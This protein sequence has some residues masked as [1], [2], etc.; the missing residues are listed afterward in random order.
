MHLFVNDSYFQI[1]YSSL[2][3]LNQ[4]YSAKIIAYVL[5]VNHIHLILY[6]ESKNHL[7]DYMRDFKK[8]TAVKL[9][10]LIEHEGRRELLEKLRFDSRKQKFKIW[11]GPFDDV[12]IRSKRVLLIK[13]NY[14]HL[15]PVKKNLVSEAE[16]YKHSSAGF[17]LKEKQPLIPI[18][19]YTEIFS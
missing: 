6:F 8:F 10:Q 17:Y 9:R 19:H 14:I 4:K 15:N 2:L 1:L 3:F 12:V 5:M 18:L 11:M 13:M 7:S 16:D